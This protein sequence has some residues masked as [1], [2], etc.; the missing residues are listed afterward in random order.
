MITFS[1]IRLFQ[2]RADILL[3]FNTDAY[4]HYCSAILRRSRAIARHYGAIF[5][6]RTP[7]RR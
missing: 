1:S 3:Y 2:L 5:S 4:Y 7:Q 6:R